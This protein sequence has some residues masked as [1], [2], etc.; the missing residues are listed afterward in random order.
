MQL[1]EPM[2]KVSEWTLNEAAHIDF[3]KFCAFERNAK[4]ETLSER[5]A[6]DSHMTYMCYFAEAAKCNIFSQWK[7]RM[8][9]VGC[10]IEAT[11]HVRTI[12]ECGRIMAL[13][14][15]C[16]RD[17]VPD[18]GIKSRSNSITSELEELMSTADAEH[19]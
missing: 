3:G 1:R 4:F 14:F 16:E 13:K 12:P 8:N 19:E 6:R 2:R 5:L 9:F 10:P 7:A 11:M 17:E 18:A 15:M